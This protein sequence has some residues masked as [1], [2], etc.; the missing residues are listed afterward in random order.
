MALQKKERGL[1]DH[2][3]KHQGQAGSR[4][5]RGNMGQR[6]CRGQEEWVRQA[7]QAKQV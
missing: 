5:A 1:W 2:R 3:R 7:K 6:L 4:W